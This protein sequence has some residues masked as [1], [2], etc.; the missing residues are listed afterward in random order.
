MESIGFI[1]LGFAV[2]F[3][4][5]QARLGESVEFDPNRIGG[6]IKFLGQRTQVSRVGMG[7]KLQQK[8]DSG[9]RSDE[10]V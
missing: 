4:Q 1:Q 9:F 3:R 10:R 8:L 5:E 6:F 7:K 2:I